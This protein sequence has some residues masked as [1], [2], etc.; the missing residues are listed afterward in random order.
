M[1]KWNLRCIGMAL[2]S[3][4][5]LMLQVS[6]TRVFS[7]TLWY[8]F[9]W[10]IV[11]IALLGFAISGTFLMIF[12]S[13]A[14]KNID[15][16][17]TNISILF[18][19]SII[20]SYLL[21]NWVPFDPVT[22]AWDDLQLFYIFVYYMLLMIPFFLSG[23]I[24]AVAIENSDQ[25]VNTVY[26]SSFLGSAVGSIFVLPFFKYLGGSGVIVFSAFIGGIGAAIFSFNLKKRT[27][28]LLGYVFLLALF[29]P[30]SSTIMP[31]KVSPYKSLNIALRYQGAILLDT[32][33]N[34]FSR[35]DVVESGFI[36]YAP[37]LSLL[38]VENIP[39]QIGIIVDGSEVNA[40][41]QYDGNRSSIDFVAYLPSFLPYNLVSSPKVLVLDSGGGQGVLT[42]LYGN[43]S[44]VI[45]VEENLNII[46]LVKKSFASFSGSIYLDPR[47]NV[48]VSDG[49]SFIQSSNEDFDI[50]DLSLTGGASAT[51]T[52]IYALSENYIYTEEAFMSFIDHLSPK[53][54]LAVQRWLLPP[55]REDI[56]VV[57][58][59]MSSLEKMGVLNPEEHIVVYR[60]WGTLNLLVGRNPFTQKQLRQIRL[61]C[62]EMGFDIVYLYDMDS[63]EV[64]KFN[65][66]PEPIYYN[67]VDEIIDNK[68]EFYNNYLFDIRPS[69][70]EKPFFFNFFKWNRVRETY[71]SLDK[72]W[73]ALVEG[74]F[75]IPIVL[76]QALILSVVF[77]LLPLLRFQK[78]QMDNSVFLIYFF[79]I[80]IGYMFIEITTI[81]RF[82]LILGNTVYSIS[83][84]FF[85][86]LLFSGFGSYYS[87]K[88]NPGSNEHIMIIT[89]IGVSSI[90]FGFISPL[91]HLILGLSYIFRLIV[92]IFMIGPI[93]FLMGMPFPLGIRLLAQTNKEIIN[94]AWALNGCASVLGSILPIIIALY[95][96]FS[97]VYVIA[98]ITYLLSIVL[99]RKLRP[100]M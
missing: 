5:S 45:A 24:L 67:I 68:E 74:G 21:S 33:W 51:S 6:Y 44:N 59:A 76:V 71:N 94:W 52:G 43:A 26:F 73:Q 69:T 3:I 78:K 7:I 56:R 63:N 93:G 40:I 2:V 19:V 98:G 66:F 22:L 31:V 72:R 55:P 90:V 47:V 39:H 91:V 11:S 17:L 57:G 60:S 82:I 10:M 15:H 58:L 61:F 81:Q 100:R 42:A 29:I 96:G 70:D 64:N 85:I 92:T 89:A 18:S 27:K 23:L 1:D 37:G 88:I 62:S 84:V 16:L 38:Y 9:V 12:P 83:S 8:H 48:V 97:R 50:I 46:N 20:F 41:T 49:R 4:A 99:V 87:S 54:V 34:S 30:F 36:R 65:R 28:L 14:K 86:L 25:R 35:I 79:F 75:L 77:V 95:F 53:G 32:Q 13:I 80:G